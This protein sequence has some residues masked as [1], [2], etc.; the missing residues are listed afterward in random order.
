MNE[1]QIEVINKSKLFK[2]RTELTRL[3]SI[4]QLIDLS[5]SDLLKI[6]I[7]TDALYRRG[8]QIISD[9]LYDQMYF[10][11]LERRYPNHPFL[12]HISEYNNLSV[13]QNLYNRMLTECK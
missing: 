11:E 4:N 2:S 1:E 9:Y 13:V 5:D 3:L 12:E 10:K 7:I 8:I 6:L